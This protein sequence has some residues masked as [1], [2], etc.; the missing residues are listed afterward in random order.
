MEMSNQ[1]QTGI[2]I[3]EETSKQVVSEV[4]GEK[5]ASDRAKGTIGGTSGVAFGVLCVWLAGRFGVAMS[6][7]VG[8]VIG[9]IAF[10]FGAAI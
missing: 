8:A 2:H 1:E 10:T 9:S 4:V 5:A 3:S 7:E 6:A